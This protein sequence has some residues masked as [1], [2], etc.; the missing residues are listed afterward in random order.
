MPPGPEYWLILPADK[1]MLVFT[2]NE[3]GCYA[4]P[5]IFAHGEQM[6]VGVLPGFVMDLELLF[7][8]LKG[9]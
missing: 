7:K 4:A 8:E 5:A 3:Q 1:T 6:P 2:L 9:I